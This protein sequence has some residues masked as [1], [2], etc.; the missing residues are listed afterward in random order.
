MDKD[1][2]ELME[3]KHEA[4]PGY[5]PVFNVVFLLAVVYLGLIL[6]KTIR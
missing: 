5:R 2:K 4:V 1:E 3:L 6:W